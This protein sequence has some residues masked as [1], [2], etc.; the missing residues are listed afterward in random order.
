[1]TD[2]SEES[3]MKDLDDD[4]LPRGPINEDEKSNESSI[5]IKFEDMKFEDKAKSYLKPL[6]L[7]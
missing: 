6:N 3:F 5:V 2:L 1:M 4:D 7:R